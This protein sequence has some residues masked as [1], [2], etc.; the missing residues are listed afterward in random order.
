MGKFEFQ[1]PRLI[2][3]WLIFT[4]ASELFGR[5]KPRE[6]IVEYKDTD[7]SSFFSGPNS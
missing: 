3:L 1:K 5:P 2:W 6:N 4:F 7:D